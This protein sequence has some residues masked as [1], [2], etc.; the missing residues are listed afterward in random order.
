RRRGSERNI[1]PLQAKGIRFVHGD[2]RNPGDFS[3]LGKFDVFI[4]A[5]AEP[6][7][8]AGLDGSPSYVFETNLVGTFHC[9]EFARI[10]CKRLIFL[11]TSRVYSIENLRN[12]QLTESGTHF[13]VADKQK[14]SGVSSHGIS[15]SFST[16]TARSLYGATK[17]AS[18]M[19]I[20]EYEAAYGLESVINR[21]GVIAGP[22]QF[23][24]VDQ[25][26]F[27][28]WVAHHYFGKPLEYKGWKGRG[29]QVRDLMHPRDLF[30]LI[31]G[32][33]A[34]WDKV[35]G[36]I[37]NAG[38]GSSNAVSLAQWSSI[39]RKITGNET[40]F[41]ANPETAAVDIPYYVSDSRKIAAAIGW[42]PQISTETIAKEITDW[43][44]ADEAQAKKIFGI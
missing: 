6:S 40:S 10:H 35:K 19:L 16:A 39:C 17:L 30:D 27:A 22:G 11:S 7:V 25:G 9:L 5:S 31:R 13:A 37:Y 8:H 26:V 38:G 2:I 24:K 44:R 14:E 23:G 43:I 33:L 41:T 42:T 4:E 18:E 36:G 3:G 28:L 29:L 20:Q 12:I 32:Q 34:Q 21:C 1:E 15:E